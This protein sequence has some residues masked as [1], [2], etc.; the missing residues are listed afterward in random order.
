MSDNFQPA[1][2]ELLA[3]PALLGAQGSGGVLPPFKVPGMR[4]GSASSTA[5]NG[6]ALQYTATLGDTLQDILVDMQICKSNDPNAQPELRIG[7]A[8]LVLAQWG[9]NLLRVNPPQSFVNVFNFAMDANEIQVCVYDEYGRFAALNL[10][11]LETTLR[12]PMF[13]SGV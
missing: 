8:L 4:N 9:K 1:L 7:A 2:N 10:L 3:M 12:M 11:N 6:N 13:N 5:L